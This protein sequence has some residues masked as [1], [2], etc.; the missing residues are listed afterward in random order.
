MSNRLHVLEAMKLMNSTDFGDEGE[1]EKIIFLASQQALKDGA[2]QSEVDEIVDYVMN[3]GEVEFKSM[4][5]IEKAKEIKHRL[6]QYMLDHKVS[7]EDKEEEKRIKLM[8][9]KEKTEAK[10]AIVP[11]GM[12]AL[13]GRDDISQKIVAKLMSIS[14]ALADEF[15]YDQ[16]AI[17]QD[18]INDLRLAGGE[19]ITDIIKGDSPIE[20]MTAEMASSFKEMGLDS[21]MA[22]QA[23]LQMDEK[24]NVEMFRQFL[25]QGGQLPNFEKSKEIK[26]KEMAIL[27]SFSKRLLLTEGLTEIHAQY[28]SDIKREMFDKLVKLDP[29]FQEDQDK[30]G[31][32]GKWIL[33]AFK[34]KRLRE[35]DLERV[36]EI[37]FDFNERKRFI[38]APNGKDIFTYKT[39]DEIRTA[40]DNIQLT[41]NQIAKQARKAKQ[42]ADLGEEAEFIGENDKWEI[43]VPKTYA[44][45]CKLGSGT[46]W[47]TASTSYQG[48]FDSYSKSGKLYVFY[49]KDGDI[50]KKFQAHVKGGVEV[51]TFMDTDDRPSI[52]FSTFIFQ[53]GLLPVLK[54]S[55][56]KNVDAIMDV[57]NMERLNKG[58]PYMYAGGK[59]KPAFA[60]I[61]K[62]VHFVKEYDKTEI[63]GFAF[64]GC[65]EMAE[66]YIPLKVASFGV[67]AFEGCEKVTIFTPKHKIKCYPSDLEFLKERIKYIDESKMPN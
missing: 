36:N 65:S 38:T 16:K 19:E 39:I 47:C 1:A 64:K 2:R 29:T 10:S 25:N 58:E 49:P 12:G 57:E 20:Q 44:A 6:E 35:R 55:E 27:E 41:A 53:Q 43:W 30:I 15:G 13:A 9:S 3:D 62:I 40:L 61:I 48:Y 63:P 17:L 56:L 50:S 21:N 22:L 23:L 8:D 42:H 24:K 37:L 33:N 46:R 67:R 54:A 32:Y 7:V 26:N 14:K 18:M 51:T 31:T 4:S 59:I 52:E 11:A 28:Y 66:I 34:Q 60:P 45:S 5:L